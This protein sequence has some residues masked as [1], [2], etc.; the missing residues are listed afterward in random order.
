[1]DAATV[2][3]ASLEQTRRALDQALDDEYRAR[4]TYRAIL[5]EFGPVRPFLNIVESE[6]RHV[7]ALVAEYRRLGLTIPPDPWPGQVDLPATLEAACLA[8]VAA[9]E[10]NVALYDRL[11][12]M[13]DDAQVLAVFQRLCDASQQRHLPAFQRCV[14]RGA[15]AGRGR[16]GRG[17]RRGG[18]GRGRRRHGGGPGPS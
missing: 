13:T 9:E 5:D 16:G 1:M 17:G 3:P 6:Q 4:A 8:G 12:A 15:G 7:D 18:G 14:D 10:E 2:T 11:L